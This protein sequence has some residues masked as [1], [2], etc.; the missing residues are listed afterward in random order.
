MNRPFEAL[1]VHVPFCR[2]KCFYCDFYSEAGRTKEGYVKLLLTELSLL[3]PELQQFPTVYFGGGTPSLMEPSFFETL[4][5]RVGQ[6]SEVTVEFNPEDA[7]PQKLRALRELGVNRVSIG[8]QSLSD[9]TLKAL[10]RR[11]TARQGLKAVEEALKVFNNVSVDLIYGVPGQRPEEFLRELETLLSLPVKHVSLYALT[12]YSETPLGRLVELGKV[13]LPPE[14]QVEECYRL[15][16]KLLEEKGL[17]RYE[18]SN[19]AL[20]GFRCKHNLHYWRLNNYLGI[21]PSA[22][23]FSDSRYRRNVSSLESYERKLAAGELPTAEEV[24][25]SPDELK[26]VKLSFGLRLTEGVELEA[27]GLKEWFQELLAADEAIGAMVEEGL[28]EFSGS[29][30]RLGERGVLTSNAVIATL[31]SKLPKS[32]P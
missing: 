32:T 24:N 5:S 27:L 14:E 8:V 13:E 2:S 7:T 17:K 29:R 1:Y 10:R 25:F 11:H 3:Q 15:G 4:L 18:I 22:A 28:L 21:G 30:L 6:F 26:E 31:L 20:E 19:F 12:P 23:S 16:A 9:T